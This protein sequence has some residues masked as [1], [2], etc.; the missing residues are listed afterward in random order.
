MKIIYDSALKDKLCSTDN[1][2]LENVLPRMIAFKSLMVIRDIQL[3]KASEA[4]K[5]AE[6]AEATGKPIPVEEEIEEDPTKMTETE[7]IS[8][9]LDSKAKGKDEAAV[10]EKSPE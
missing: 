2:V 10:L 7:I 8:K 6:K 9:K 3:R 1:N 4:K 5:A